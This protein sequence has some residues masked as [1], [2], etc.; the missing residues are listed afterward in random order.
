[1]GTTRISIRV[2]AILAAVILLMGTAGF[3]VWIG[4]PQDSRIGLYL[5]L[6]GPMLLGLL[7][8][9]KQEATDRSVKRVETKTEAVKTAAQHMTEAGVKAMTAAITTA[10]ST[11]ATA[12]NGEL[13]AKIGEAVSRALAEDRAAEAAAEE[14]EPPHG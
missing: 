12:G 6:A 11:G 4:D 1:M 8:L 13:A 9:V 5:G 10:A 2:V 3:L 7:T 14:G